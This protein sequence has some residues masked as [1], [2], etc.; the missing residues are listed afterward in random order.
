MPYQD[1]LLRQ[2]LD[3]LLQVV[4]YFFYTTIADRCGVGAAH[5]D[6]IRVSGPGERH[7]LVAIALK[8]F[9]PCLPGG[10]VHPETMNKRDSLGGS[11]CHDVLVLVRDVYLQGTKVQA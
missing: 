3:L 8:E 2:R 9:F 10:P 11:G 4:G 7:S 6:G 5:S 1:R